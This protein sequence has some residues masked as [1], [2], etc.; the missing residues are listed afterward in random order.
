MWRNWSPCAL[1]VG[2]LNGPA[3]MEYSMAVPQKKS[4][5]ELPYDAAIPLLVM[6]PK[7]FK[8]GTQTDICTPMFI[9]TLFTI[10]TRYKQ[11]RCPSTNV[12]KIMYIT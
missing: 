11:P 2:M 12:N 5:I 7:E 6:Y 3:T 8:A 9:I 4:N 10:A 1:L